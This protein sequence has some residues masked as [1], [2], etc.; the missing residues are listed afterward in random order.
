M[1]DMMDDLLDGTLDDLADIP[2]FK[3]FP[4]G[5]HK[6]LVSFEAKEINKF[7][8][9]EV[10]LKAIETV[11]LAN[12]SD[13]P[14]DKGAQTSAAY[15]LK[16]SDDFVAKMGQGRI[17]EIF[18]ALAPMYP[19]AKSM[20]ELMV[21]ANNSEMNV[22]TNIRSGKLKDGVTPQYTEIVQMIAP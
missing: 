5:V 20:K 19:D 11:E 16:H 15:F 3:P 14:L 9:I 22:A 4:V 2:E 10:K 21:A 6:C 17:K 18:K 12:P 8:A 1:A 13:T 7:P